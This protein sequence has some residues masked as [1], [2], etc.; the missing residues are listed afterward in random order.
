[1]IKH[2]NILFRII[3]SLVLITFLVPSVASSVEDYDS[4]EEAQK[5]S[6][7]IL[8]V[9]YDPTREFFKQYNKEFVSYW[10]N[11]TGQDLLVKQSHGGSGKQARGVIDG[12]RADVVTLAL[13]Y[14]IDII[15]KKTQKFPENWQTNYQIIHLHI[16]Q[17]LYF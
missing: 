3:R 10:K 4:K 6:I 7:E 8:N 13:A 16:L 9:S 11:K 5:K 14:D 15:A 12:L 1:M 17:L 2:N